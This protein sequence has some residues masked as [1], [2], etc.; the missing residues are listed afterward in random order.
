MGTNYI[1]SRLPR[2]LVWTVANLLK[3]IGGIA[4]YFKY[5]VKDN[6]K[7]MSLRYAWKCNQLI[8][9]RILNSLSSTLRKNRNIPIFSVQVENIPDY[10]GFGGELYVA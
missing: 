4:N 8:S 9:G 6:R 1:S 5:L 3:K 2:A 7:N 10:N